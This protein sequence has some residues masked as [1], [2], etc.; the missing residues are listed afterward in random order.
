MENFLFADQ[1]KAE[2]ISILREFIR[3]NPD[4]REL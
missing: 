2:K 4:A 1:Q 3:S